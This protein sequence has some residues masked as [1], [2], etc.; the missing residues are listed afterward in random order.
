MTDEQ[1]VPL[2]TLQERIDAYKNTFS[3]P[4]DWFWRANYPDLDAA[5]VQEAHA[6]IIQ[7][8]GHR[9]D[10]QRAM[11]ELVRWI[12]T[13][14]QAIAIG[15]VV[16]KSSPSSEQTE[17]VASEVEQAQRTLDQLRERRM[18]PSALIA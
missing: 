16:A 14:E 5:Q 17:R 8:A 15:E 1:L 3:K 11:I 6:T 10:F 9:P 13:A 2:A 12:H 4:S 18:Y 7:I